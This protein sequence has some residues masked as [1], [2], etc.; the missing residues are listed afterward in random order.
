MLD[1]QVSLG[2]ARKQGS[3]DGMPRRVDYIA[4]PTSLHPPA[5]ALPDT[6][7]TNNSNEQIIHLKMATGKKQHDSHTATTPSILP[8]PLHP[9]TNTN[10]PPS[11]RD[12]HHA[13]TNFRRMT[14]FS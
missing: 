7:H 1:F 3:S 2:A 14:Q 8:L 11:E 10:T 5:Q 4:L 6:S 13:Q 12:H 9:P